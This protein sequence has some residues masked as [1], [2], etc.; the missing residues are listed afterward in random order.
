MVRL[1]Q[2]DITSLRLQTS[3]LEKVVENVLG[4][5]TNGNSASDH[6]I[7]SSEFLI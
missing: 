4:Y 5:G 2:Y 7:P 6:P 1:S 3:T